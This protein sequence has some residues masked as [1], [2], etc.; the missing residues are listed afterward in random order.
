MLKLAGTPINVNQSILWVDRESQMNYPS[1]IQGLVGMG[2]TTTPNFLDLAYSDNLIS[3]PVFALGL[4]ESTGQ[5]VI[6]YN[7]IPE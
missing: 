2:F 1:D 7:G 4:V 3:S 5:S 6:Y